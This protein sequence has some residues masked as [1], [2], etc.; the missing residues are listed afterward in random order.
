MK[1]EVK[2]H[3]GCQI[4][5]VNE[6]NKVYVY[7]STADVKYLKRLV[8]QAEKQKA[9][10]E[11]EYQHIRV[12]KIYE[13]LQTGIEG[14]RE[15]ENVGESDTL[16]PSQTISNTQTSSP[17]VT[18]KMQYVY[19]KNFIEFFE[20]AGFEQVDYLIGAL[21]YFIEH[22]IN[23][24]K[25]QNVSA[26]IFQDKFASIRKTCESNPL[27]Q[28]ED[29]FTNCSHIANNSEELTK[30][31]QSQILD[32][33]IKTILDRSEQ[34]F[35]EMG[36]PSNSSNSQTLERFI[37]IPVG[38]C[39]GDLTF[40]NILFNG[41]NYY[42]IDFLDSFVETP[43]Q[44]IVK[45]RQDTAHRWSQLMYTKRYDAVRLHI[46][47]DKIDREIDTYFSNKYQWYR[48]YYQVM[49]LM[50][51]LRILPYAHEV[52]VIE[53]LKNTLT[54][55]LD[56]ISGSNSSNGSNSTLNR[57]DSNIEPLE[58][59]KPLNPQAKSLLVPVA[60]DKPEY[61]NGLP[62]VFGL[63]KDGVIICIKSIMG[64]ELDKFDN[65]YFTVLKKHDE[66]FFIVDSLNLQFKRLG[67][68]NAKVVVLDEPTQDQAETIYQTIQQEHIE[69]SLFIKDADCFFKTELS[70]SNSVA[71]FPIEELEVLTPKDKS[72]VAV[73]DMYYLT[74]IIEKS[75]VGHY[76]S[77]GGY[78]IK[79]VETFLHYYQ[80][81]RGFGRLYLSHIIY[82]MLLD[83]KTF[84]P[85]MVEEYKDW[86][87][88]NDYRR[89]E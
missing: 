71:I 77:A 23:K 9:A 54:G 48:D 52:K 64:L 51:I 59:A 63:D 72:Y 70:D 28:V 42:L 86:G 15:V 38:L 61:A 87:T 69:G 47:L 83:K 14:K 17:Q 12:P 10:A 33:E 68:K 7:K 27:Y 32:E 4:D 75:V 44:D 57:C 46:V 26:K 5:V 81:L 25:L 89:Y 74:N 24:C 55:I 82:A 22:E 2:G 62:Y 76:I 37:T 8:L 20:Q 18:I 3:S 84:R 29:K 40:S 58:P 19:S 78:S 39:H 1:I 35:N 43:L 30:L 34:I 21:E 66:R 13:I 53:Y 60:A 11:V 80:Q 85:M 41:N 88:M 73:D 6:D 79:R 50:N 31:K 16:V 49:Q 67:I 45:I 36:T 65:I 56:G